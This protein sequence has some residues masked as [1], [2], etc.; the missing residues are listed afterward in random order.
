MSNDDLCRYQRYRREGET[1]L[2]AFKRTRG[3]VRKDDDLEEFNWPT[4]QPGCFCVS[5]MNWRTAMR[6]R[7][8]FYF[9]IAR[10][11]TYRK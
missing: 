3:D 2:M 10:R 9:P 6:V 4:R 8:Y 7:P 11:G 5:L 1:A